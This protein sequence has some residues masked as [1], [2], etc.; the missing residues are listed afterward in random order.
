MNP[1][2]T[3]SLAVLV[4]LL[5][6]GLAYSQKPAVSLSPGTLDF[7]AQALV[8]VSASQAITLTNGGDG[9]LIISDI[10]SVN[11]E[12][13]IS[14]TSTCNKGAQVA[15]KASCVIDVT[16][17]PAAA[18]KRAGGLIITDNDGGVPD[19]LQVVLLTGTAAAAETPQ[20]SGDQ[21][22]AVI[23]GGKEGIPLKSDLTVKG[24]VSVQAVLIPF[25]IGRRVFGREI[26]KK[27]AIV[28]LTINN[29]STDAALIVQGA[30][31]D[32]SDWVLAGLARPQA[33]PQTCVNGTEQDVINDTT[34][35]S[36]HQACTVPTQVASVEARIARGQ[37]LD[38]QPW[39]KRNLVVNGLTLLGSVASA[40]SFSLSERGLIKGIAA[41][42]GTVVPGLGVFLPDGTVG[43]LNRISDF[44]YQT[45][46]VI[47][48]QASDVIVCF[49][50]IDRF[51]TPGFKR[52]FLDEPA[53]LLSPYQVLLDKRARA[54]AS[55]TLKDL[56]IDDDKRKELADALPCFV[57]LSAPKRTGVS[58]TNDG[59]KSVPA[60]KE[61]DSS[62]AST[63]PLE[64]LMSSYAATRCKPETTGGQTPGQKGQDGESTPAK[65]KA[66]P[67]LQDLALLVTLGKVSLNSIRVVVDG[68]MTVETGAI[69]AKIDSVE[70]DDGNNSPALWTTPGVKKG[71]IKGL[72]LT[73]GKL[74]IAEAAKLGITEITMITDGST[75]Q[76]LRFSFN[77][78]K[79]I[80]S[81]EKLTFV[82]TKPDGKDST[83]TV[84]SMTYVF[85]VSYASPAPT[86]SKV[87][88]KD[89]KIT[90]TGTNF[91]DTTQDPL[92]VVLH[93]SSGGSDVTVKPATP[94]TATTIE[95]DPPLALKDPGCSEVHVT[96]GTASA[97]SGNNTFAV[98]PEP[99]IKS[100]TRV[101]KPP[102][103]VEVA[104]SGFVD[105]SPCGGSAIVF[106]LL[107]DK[108]GATPV[109]VKATLAKGVTATFDLPAAAVK[110]SPSWKVQV[111]LGK[112][113][114][115]TAALK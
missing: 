98:L 6:N 3:C 74:T 31:I 45:N 25:E 51:L 18:G 97:P 59:S 48:Q 58:K 17:A 115:D 85:V 67:T 16:F 22:P 99:T 92:K 9:P 44:G 108:A 79:A 2:I 46:K 91:R 63:T 68:V 104:G 32:Y 73:G 20:T 7:G 37:L 72:Y 105:T 71:T 57:A 60:P 76:A 36:P 40:Y 11:T 89:N 110:T 111:L 1:R 21:S 38:S 84:D 102:K 15:P 33:S 95:L 4:S 53:L 109:P 69:P 29:R 78:S 30:F 113:V 77:T 35:Q 14:T 80:P 12:F 23:K 50:P 27:Y 39:T 114:K 5:S 103:T 19:S 64:D 52:I 90:V 42:N 26:A 100:A 24:N 8:S 54:K 10:K 49:F 43:Q 96:V 55:G 94:P 65:P 86:I 87:E 41:W 70:F 93:P 28:Q 82:V 61:S 112:D 47:G 83:K 62:N 81:G 56:G 88:Y 66:P 13:A 34:T 75:D 106:Q 107:E 101:G